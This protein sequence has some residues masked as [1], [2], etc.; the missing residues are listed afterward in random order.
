MYAEKNL[1]KDDHTRLTQ[2]KK[3]KKGQN[4]SLDHV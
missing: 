1:Q 4:V 2:E 3:K